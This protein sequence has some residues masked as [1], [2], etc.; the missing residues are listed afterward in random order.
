[1]KSLKIRSAEKPIKQK[2]KRNRRRSLKNISKSIRLLGVNAAGL[3]SKMT[4]FRKIISDLNPAI[5]F[6]EETKFKETGKMRSMN[7]YIV[8]EKVRANGTGGGGIAI[9]CLKDLH[10]ALIREGKD[11]DGEGMERG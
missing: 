5:F 8:F 9:G 4:T 3:S 11:V 7:D 6:I 2:V 10:P 1:M